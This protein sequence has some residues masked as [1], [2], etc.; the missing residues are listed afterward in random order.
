[1]KKGSIISSWGTMPIL[2]LEAR[3]FSSMSMLAIFT[4]PLVLLTKPARMLIKVDFP[5]PLGPSNPKK[6]PFGISR[7]ILSIAVFFGVLVV[8][9]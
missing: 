7:F 4:V 3:G 8:F 5:A 9:L 1:M 2:N 6:E